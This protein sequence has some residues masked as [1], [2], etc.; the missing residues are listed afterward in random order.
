[1]V[2][3]LLHISHADL[4][5]WMYGLLAYQLILLINFSKLCNNHTHKINYLFTTFTI[6][7]YEILKIDTSVI[8]NASVYFYYTDIDYKF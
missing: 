8:D 7:S 1:M 5:I 6:I 3:T 2:V 4:L